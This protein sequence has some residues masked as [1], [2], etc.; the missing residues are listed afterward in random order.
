[1]STTHIQHDS[2]VRHRRMNSSLFPIKQTSSSNHLG[3]SPR[4][5]TNNNIAIGINLPRSLV[6]MIPTPESLKWLPTVLKILFII[7]PLITTLLPTPTIILLLRIYPTTKQALLPMLFLITIIP[8]ISITPMPEFPEQH[9]PY[10][11]LKPTANPQIN[12]IQ[13]PITNVP[14]SRRAS[15]FSN[16]QNVKHASVSTNQRRMSTKRR[17]N[18]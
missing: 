12:N 4:A 5:A 13:A 18:S 17:K 11:H 6:I 1:M 14:P 8:V 3:L 15:L 2:A 7:P 16:N 9:R 10:F